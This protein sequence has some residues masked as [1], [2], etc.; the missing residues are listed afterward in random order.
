M[1]SKLQVNDEVYCIDDTLH[2]K[3]PK[4]EVDSSVLTLKRNE[5]YTVESIDSDYITLS[6]R[7]HFF[8]Q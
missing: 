1:E 3:K 5:L 8:Q 7:E 4:I 2:K 6:D